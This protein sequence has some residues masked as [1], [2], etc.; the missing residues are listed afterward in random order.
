MTRSAPV[1]WKKFNVEGARGAIY[2]DPQTDEPYLFYLARVPVVRQ[3]DGGL[4]VLDE[5][6]VGIKQ[7]SDGRCEETPAHLLL[8]LTL[9]TAQQRMP[10]ALSAEWIN[11]A[12][13]TQPH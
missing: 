1:F 12:D 10:T 9:Q 11:L 6:L 3:T 13:K 5:M 2:F 8:T 7:F 4:H